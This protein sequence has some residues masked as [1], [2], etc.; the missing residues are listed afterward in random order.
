M[1][2]VGRIARGEIKSDS[3]VAAGTLAISIA[4]YRDGVNPIKPFY[5]VIYMCINR[6][7]RIIHIAEYRSAQSFYG[8]TRPRLSAAVAAAATAI[9]KI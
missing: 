1:A 3:R 8:T 5:R 4:A 9:V 2:I 6:I 7:N